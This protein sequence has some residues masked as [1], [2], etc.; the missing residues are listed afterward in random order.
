MGQSSSRHTDSTRL[1]NGSLRT[2]P[3]KH[4]RRYYHS[5]DEEES[6]YNV[7]GL[8]RRI[9]L[10]RSDAKSIKSSSRHLKTAFNNVG[11]EFSRRT[12]S[13]R[14]SSKTPVAQTYS[15]QGQR[16]Y[17]DEARPAHHYDAKAPLSRTQTS[18]SKHSKSGSQGREIRQK[19]ECVIC[20]DSRSLS[21]FP[22]DPVT[23]QCNHNSDV[24]RRCLRTWIST[25]FASRMWDEIN[26]PVCTARLAYDDVREFAPSEVF[27]TYRIL[28]KK[29]AKEAIPGWHWCPGKG[30]K[31]GQVVGATNKLRC[32]KCKKD[33]CVEHNMVWHSRETCQEYE[34]RYV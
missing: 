3:S 1:Q 13:M 23:T 21:R 20:T 4:T 25:S 12:Q 30:C 7:P 17:R 24:C 32:R 2:I 5:D 6:Q 34:Y 18:K 27:R 33:Y 16:F 14:H 22:S 29:A 10:H 8:R 19:K 15:T 31:S 9:T 28:S 26:C 11:P